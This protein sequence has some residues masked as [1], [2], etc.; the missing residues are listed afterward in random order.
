LVSSPSILLNPKKLSIDRKDERETYRISFDRRSAYARDEE[1][2]LGNCTFV[3]L[4]LTKES[5]SSTDVLSSD[6][7]FVKSKLSLNLLLAK[8]L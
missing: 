2:E 4:L 5:T 8:S 3:M 7:V 6:V 1:T